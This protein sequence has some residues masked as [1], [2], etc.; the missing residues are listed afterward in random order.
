MVNTT[1]PLCRKWMLL[2]L[3]VSISS[4]LCVARSEGRGT[5][6]SSQSKRKTSMC[7]EDAYLPRASTSSSRSVRLLYNCT[8]CSS[9]DSMTMGMNM[10]KHISP[11]HAGSYSHTTKSKALISL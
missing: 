6:E 10:I 1:S 8:S 2:F 4:G 11:D 3:L 7:A 5:G 9:I